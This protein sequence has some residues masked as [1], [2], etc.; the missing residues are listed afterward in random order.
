MFSKLLFAFA[1]AI[2][3]CLIAHDARIPLCFT[4]IQAVLTGW[5]FLAFSHEPDKTVRTEK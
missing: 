2:R 1:Q 5:H 4:Q 3:T